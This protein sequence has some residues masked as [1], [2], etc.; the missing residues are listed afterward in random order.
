MIRQRLAR[1]FCAAAI[2]RH[3][4]RRQRRRQAIAHRLHRAELRNVVIVDGDAGDRRA[5]PQST[6]ILRIPLIARLGDVDR[7]GDDAQTAAE[8]GQKAHQITVRMSA[9]VTSMPAEGFQLIRI[10]A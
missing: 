2:D 5:A 4:Q 9:P 10:A 3:R 6:P 7:V 1:T 8:A